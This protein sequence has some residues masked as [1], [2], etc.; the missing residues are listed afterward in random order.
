MTHTIYDVDEASGQV[1]WR[2]GGKHSSFTG[3][4]ND[5]SSQHDAKFVDATHISVFDNGGGVGPTVHKHSRAVVVKFDFAAR[6]ATLVV[7][8]QDSDFL[9]APTQGSTEVLPNGNVFVGWAGQ[10][11]AS[12]F[13]RTGKEIYRSVVPDHNESYREYLLPWRG[14]PAT[15]PSVAASIHGSA[16]TVWASWNGA[17]EV[18]AWRVL[19]GSSPSSVTARAGTY[20][21]SGFETAMTVPSRAAYVAVQAL[22][23]DGSV[24]A[25]SRP[26]AVARH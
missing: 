10:R 9:L 4:A 17:T 21:S 24:L 12:E 26:A 15:V 1:L 23:A 2:L 6:K 16:M 13:D 18:T 5:F 22:R 25:T 11:F 19:T 7:D 20:R 8:D 3:N 14:S